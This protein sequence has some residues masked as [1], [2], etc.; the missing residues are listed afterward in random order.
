MQDIT[1]LWLCRIKAGLS[2]GY[3]PWMASQAFSTRRQARL[4]VA[5]EGSAS[6][7]CMACGPG[8]GI[9]VDDALLGEPGVELQ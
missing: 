4:S 7:A 2:L 1:W 8:L 3:L 5:R 6:I 9:N